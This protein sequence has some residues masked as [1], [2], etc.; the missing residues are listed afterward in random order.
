[1]NIKTV[2]IMSGPDAKQQ[3]VGAI[4]FEWVSAGNLNDAIDPSVPVVAHR[5]IRHQWIIPLT[6]SQEKRDDV[7]LRIGEELARN[8]SSGEVDGYHWREE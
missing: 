1:M 8:R 6:G 2:M 7:A 3:P 5:P 4:H